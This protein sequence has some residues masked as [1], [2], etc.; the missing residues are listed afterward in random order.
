MGM[1]DAAGSNAHRGEQDDP[2][3]QW[4]QFRIRFSNG[5]VQDIREIRE[6]PILSDYLPSASDEAG[7]EDQV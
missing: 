7:P 4:V 3:Y 2:D 1:F 6:R 5:R